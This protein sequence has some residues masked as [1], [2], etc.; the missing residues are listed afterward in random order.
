VS[1]LARET[2]TCET[3]GT[4]TITF[5]PPI[6][7]EVSGV[8]LPI[9]VEEMVEILDRHVPDFDEHSVTRDAEATASA[10]LAD[11][12]MVIEHAYRAEDED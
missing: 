4:T 10:V 12:R 9:T 8:Y 1:G 5:D 7:V 2:T 6:E 11:I 3:C